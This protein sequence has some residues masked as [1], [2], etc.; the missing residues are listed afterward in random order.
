MDKDVSDVYSRS[1]TGSYFV[2]AVLGFSFWFFMAVPFASHRETYGWLAGVPSES[3]IQ[4]LSF[5]QSSTYRPLAQVVTWSAFHILNPRVFPTSAPR[6]ALLQGVIYGLFLAAWWLMFRATLQQ[7]TFA[8]IACV[9]GGVFF[10]GYVHLFHIYGLFY[11]PVILMLGS[12]LYCY[13]SGTFA[14][15]ETWFA[16]IAIGL[17]LWHPFATALFLG[18]Y[19]GFYLETFSQHSK[20]QHV[21]ALLI[22][23]VGAMADH[24]PRHHFPAGSDAFPEQAARISGELSDE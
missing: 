4:Q 11:V 17:A 20:A 18:F 12:L 23:L 21:R 1:L 7:K 2:L 22:L 15:K 24:W 19:F 3:F 14:G 16:A 5:G 13:A 10:S 6:Q 9:A 8:S